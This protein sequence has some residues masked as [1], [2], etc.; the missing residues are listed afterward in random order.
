[1]SY[2]QPTISNDNW[3]P[4]PGRSSLQPR[5]PQTSNADVLRGVNE[6]VNRAEVICRESEAI[7]TETVGE[8]AT[9][10]ESLG[11]T[12]ERVLEA[13]AGLETTNKNLKYIHFK[14]VTNKIL[15]CSIILMELI[16]IGLQLYLKF[17][18]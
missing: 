10:R 9:Q 7:A 2:Q 6:R 12:R 13:N 15:L 11:R 16:I 14:I 5:Q 3:Q 8:L 4:A 18:K 1:M 17:S